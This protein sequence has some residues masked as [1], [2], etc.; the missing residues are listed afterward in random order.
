LLSAE[1]IAQI[2]RIE[3]KAKHLVS[4]VMSGQY[5]S[6]FKGRGM[7]FDEVREYQFGDD[8]RFIDWNVTARMGSP[9]VKVFR[10]EREL[11]IVLM[12]DV[13]GSQ[14]FATGVQTKLAFAAQIAAV[15]AFLAQKNNDRVGLVLFSDHIEAYIP[16]S[17]GRSH[18]WHII[19]QVLTH[20]SKGARTDLRVPLEFLQRTLKRKA[21]C[22]LVSDFWC[23]SAYDSVLKRVSR[24]H[25]LLAVLTSDPSEVLVKNMGMLQFE[26][27]ES[28]LSLA[29]DSSD[30]G[31]HKKL[32]ALY[33]QH[34]QGLSEQL[35]SLAIDH[36]ALTTA[37]DIATGLARLM[38]QH[39]SSGGM[40]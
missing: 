12:L 19:R 37:D 20:K 18:I 33:R 21:L 4:D 22:F 5:A 8:I 29:M 28:G 38:R 34:R 10:E 30:K 27:A 31:L 26:D 2:R 36:V 11:S 13:S 32:D 24:H 40:R 39:Q 25:E 7:E 17:K 9:Y 15:L 16:P 23:E 6:A 3:L 35:K 14:H 1:L